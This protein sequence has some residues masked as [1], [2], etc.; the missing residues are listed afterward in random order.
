MKY[1]VKGEEPAEFSEWKKRKKRVRESGENRIKIP[2]NVK[3]NLRAA[4]IAEQGRICCYC[5]TRIADDTSHIEH[6]KPISN[7][8]KTN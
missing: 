4:L 5:E 2:K 7:F 1:I 6:I 3:Q 8:Q